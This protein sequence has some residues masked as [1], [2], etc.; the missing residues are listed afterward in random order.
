MEHPAVVLRA[1]SPAGCRVE[2]PAVVLQVVPPAERLEDLAVHRES[3]VYLR[4]CL[5][6]SATRATGCIRNQVPSSGLQTVVKAVPQPVFMAINPVGS[7]S[8][9]H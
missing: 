8:T 4:L 6:L 7:E 1:A 9:P 5:G 2:R 3:S